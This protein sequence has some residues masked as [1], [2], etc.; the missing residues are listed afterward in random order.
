MIR[1]CRG[2]AALILLGCLLFTSCTEPPTVVLDEAR[3]AGREVASFPHASEDYFKDMD[4]G[5]ALD[6]NE[7]K[8]RNMWNVWTGGNDRLWNHMTEFTFGAFDLLK[9]LSS[10]PSQGYS[11]TNRWDYLGLVNEPCFEPAKGADKNRRGLWLDVRSKDCAADPFENE[12]K[13]PGVAIGARGKPLGDGTTNPVGSYYGYAS[14]VMGLRLFP[15]P[16]FDEKAAKAWDPER[17]Y[18]DPK[19]YN[20]KKLVRPYRVGMSCGF[21]HI[22]PSPVNPPADPGNPKFANLSSS[23][24]AQYMWVDRLFIFNANKPEGQTNFMYQLAHSY[25]PG[26]MDTSLISTDGIN[27]PR[28]MNAVYAFMARM[29][30]AKKIGEEK[31]AGGELDNKQFNDVIGSGPLLDFYNKKDATVWTPHVLKDGADSVGLLGALNRVYLNI[32]LYSEEW[33]RH[34]N[35]VVGG[36]EI[37]P[38]KIADAQKNSTYWQAT[39]AGTPNTA[40]FFLKAAQPDL[41]KNAPGGEQY[42][43]ADAA[44]LAQGKTVFADTCARCHSSKAP[45]PPPELKLNA[46]C[47]GGGYLACFKRYWTWTQSDDYKAQMRKIVQEDDFLKDNYLSTDAR[48]PVTLLRTNACSPL[49]TNGLSGNIWDNF[50]S[51]SYKQLPSVGT[52][53]FS[54][55]Y[56]GAP[57]PYAMPAGGRGYTRV[58]SLISVW[59]TAPFLL[60]NT[61]GPFD[62]SPSVEARMKVFEA[63]IEQMLWPEKRERDTELGKKGVGRIDRTDA[64]SNITI[65]LGYVPE[66]L[67]PLQGTLHRWLPRLVSEGG[68][69]V[70]GP[71]PKGVPVNMLANLKLRAEGNEDKL[72]H[73]KNVGTLLLRLKGDLATLPQDASDEALREKFANLREP[74]LKL[75]KCADFVVNRGHY[76]GTAEFNKH[77]GLSNDEKAFG[78]EPEL[79]DADKRALIAF[80]KT[81]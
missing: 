68:D 8:G 50:S 27:N 18:T 56:T 72:E 40:L 1:S 67:Q 15:N 3:R 11:R 7:V 9:I 73:L 30:M 51:Q 59:S 26:A 78:K 81:F 69:I 75:N 53:T 29:G 33:L 23:V 74:L 34:F 41:L 45:A 55:P 39:E 57:V 77:D 31:L 47:A 61:V 24:G 42:L 58:P 21:C 79:S 76:F 65:P 70:L 25:R 80:L 43:N 52:V 16:D 13:Y 14:G 62:I 38:I 64:R 19:Y 6:A 66:A 12:S 10:H 20:D 60:N 17:Y 4:S 48:I 44:T 5:V 46:Q 36:K 54:D 37:S 22:G 49:A 63:S 32:G 28:T 2:Q 35:P 71:I